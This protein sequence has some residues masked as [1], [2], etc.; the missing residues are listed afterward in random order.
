MGLMNPKHYLAVAIRYL[1]ERRTG[2]PKVGETL[3]YAG[4]IFY[5]R[6]FPDMLQ[7]CVGHLRSILESYC[8]VASPPDDYAIGDL[9]SHL[10]ALRLLAV[11]RNDTAMTALIDRALMQRPRALS[12]SQW[13]TA[14]EAIGRRRIQLEERI[15]DPNRRFDQDSPEGLLHT[16]LP[17]SGRGWAQAL[18][19]S[20][21]H[22]GTSSS[23]H[24]IRA[25]T[26][27]PDESMVSQF[28]T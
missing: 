18:V 13:Q 5:A 1:L 9:M 26:R 23:S 11:H 4:I 17:P 27:I 2:W 8:E 20:A 10:W 14:Q 12:D 15:F 16:L 19:H 28:E 6:N 22:T 24:R 25:S 3:A 21:S 7:S